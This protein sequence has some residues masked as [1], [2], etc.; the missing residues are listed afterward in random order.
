MTITTWLLVIWG[1]AAAPYLFVPGI[2]SKAECERVANAINTRPKATDSYRC[3]EYT[4][5]GK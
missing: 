3:I 5:G 4:M 1:S 2:A